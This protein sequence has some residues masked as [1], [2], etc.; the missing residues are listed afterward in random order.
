MFLIYVELAY[1]VVNNSIISNIPVGKIK[2]DVVV[3]IDSIHKVI[4]FD[5]STSTYMHDF[6]K[7]PYFVK[8][9]YTDSKNKVF[10]IYSSDKNELKNIGKGK[11]PFFDDCDGR[12][13]LVEANGIPIARAFAFYDRRF[14][15]EK[16]QFRDKHYGEDIKT[17]W[18]GFFES[19]NSNEIASNILE[20]CECYLKQNFDVDIIIANAEFN[21]N[22]RIGVLSEGFEHTPF[23]LEGYNPNYYND[24]FI[25][26]G[27]DV[28]DFYDDGL[29]NH[30]ECRKENRVVMNPSVKKISNV[31]DKWYSFIVSKDSDELVKLIEKFQTRE[32]SLDNDSRSIRKV[33]FNSIDFEVE[34]L[35]GF[36]NHVWSV[37]NHPHYRKMTK[38]EMET[39]KNDLL[40]VCSQDLTVLLEE[41][42]NEN[43]SNIIGALIGVY[44]I[45][46]TIR[47][48]DDSFMQET[49]KLFSNDNTKGAISLISKYT[50]KINLFFRD[51]QIIRRH[52]DKLRNNP[53]N[54]EEEVQR[55]KFLPKSLRF[56]DL[57]FPTFANLYNRF[58][59]RDKIISLNYEKTQEQYKRARILIMGVEEKLRKGSYT[60]R[61]MNEFFKN[62]SKR[63]PSIED[64]SG[65]LVAQ[66]NLDMARPLERF[67]K[68]ALSYNVYTKD[69]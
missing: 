10:P 8:S 11:N 39:L 68:K 26:S 40:L 16:N 66:V 14:D 7:M 51:L 13:F 61:M 45:N 54:L 44:D 67:G 63:I 46:E 20:Y 58:S 60:L 37:G 42:S 49:G 12:Y 17:G 25:N 52:M 43:D 34:K 29:K 5:K 41:K 57:I 4:M 32:Y 9:Y 53:L 50:D 31:K 62:T 23:I 6:L 18:I 55:K 19:I 1:R 22:G 28:R 24:M 2:G 27:Y 64:V 38:K 48:I 30:D 56:A 35:I 59:S 33:S 3:S 21:G 65:S 36:Y 15:S 47:E 69:I